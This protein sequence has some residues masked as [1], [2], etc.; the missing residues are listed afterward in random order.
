M[1]CAHIPAVSPSC[2]LTADRQ[3]STRAT[4]QA[5]GMAVQDRPEEPSEQQLP[6]T[7][8]AQNLDLA[9][10]ILTAFYRL[11]SA[12]VSCLGSNKCCAV[13]CF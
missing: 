7:S 5:I 13:L 2:W 4:L 12:Q 10:T 3:L 11:A 8:P 6:G 1:A 9:V